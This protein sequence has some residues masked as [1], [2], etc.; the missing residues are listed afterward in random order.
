MALHKARPVFC[1]L[2][3]VHANAFAQVP[4]KPGKWELTGVFKGLPFGD[5]AERVRTVCISEAA[6]GSI[7]EQELMTAAPA[8]SD[9]DSKPP[10][11]CVYSNVRRVSA[12]SSWDVACESPTV[13]GTGKA[14]FAGEQVALSETLELKMPFG[15][16]FIQH[17]VLARRLGDCS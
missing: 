6:F 9:D 1:L 2:I 7:P 14:T 8:P 13:K 16:R 10:P 4:V 17:V 3:A 15:S 11:K 5:P 12:Q